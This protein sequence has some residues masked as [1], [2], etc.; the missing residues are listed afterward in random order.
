MFDAGDNFFIAGKISLLKSL[1]RSNAQ[2]RHQVGV[3]TKG[4]AHPSPAGVP[5][6][7]DIGCKCPV[8]AG[9]AHFLRGLST[10]FLN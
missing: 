9:R 10:D 3:F 5:G 7:I 1:H 2:F 8:H 4:L 6:H